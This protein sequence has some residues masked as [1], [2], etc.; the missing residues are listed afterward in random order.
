M[1][2]VNVRLAERNKELRAR[3]QELVPKSA[4]IDGL[5]ALH[6]YKMRS[7]L[8]RPFEFKPLIIA[9]ISGFFI[10]M[11]LNSF[12]RPV[13]GWWGGAL[14]LVLGFAAGWVFSGRFLLGDGVKVK[15]PFQ[16]KEQ[17]ALIANTVTSGPVIPPSDRYQFIQ[18]GTETSLENYLWEDK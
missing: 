18:A 10:S 14:G 8:G 11:V 7:F 15:H 12:L 4:E 2:E 9:G 13:L 16:R 1:A 17:R 3:Y 5:T 6:T